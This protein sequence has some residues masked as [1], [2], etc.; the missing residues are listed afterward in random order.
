LENLLIDTI[1][2]WTVV[3]LAFS[4][5][6]FTLFAR[7]TIKLIKQHYDINMLLYALEEEEKRKQHQ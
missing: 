6:V 4:L 2:I 1:A 3:I 5:T 7:F